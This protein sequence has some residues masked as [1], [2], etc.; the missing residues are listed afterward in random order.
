MKLSDYIGNKKISSDNIVIGID[1]GSRQAKAVLLNGDDFY[2][3]LTATGFDMNDTAELL[4][5]ELLG[6]SGLKREDIRYIVC[7]GYGRVAVSFP[8]IQSSIVTEIA[9]HGM[10][11]H[12]LAEDVKTIIDIGGQDSKAVKIDPQTGKVLDFA[13]NDKCAAG[14]GRFLERISAVLGEDVNTIGEI[15]VRSENP[16]TISAQCIVFAESE[17]VSGRAKGAKVEDL[18]A[19]INVSVVTRV[20]NLVSRIG[21][22]KNILFTGGVSNNI[23]IR[24]AFEKYLGIPFVDSKLDTVFAGAFGA[25]IFAIERSALNKS[26]INEESDKKHVNLY[27]LQ[28]AVENEKELIASGRTGKKKTVGYT[29]AYVPVEILSSADVAY[30]R[31]IHA[32]TQDEVMAGESVTQSVFCDMTKS[33]LGQFITENPLTK[34]TDQV[35]TFYTC[36]C[37]KNTV[38]AINNFYVPATM[39]NMPRLREEKFSLDYFRT[40]VL[41]FKEDVERLT[42]K[43]ITDEEINISI[44]LYNEAKKLIRQISE[45][46]KNDNPLISGS[47]FKQIAMSYYYLPVDILLRELVKIREQLNNIDIPK[48]KSNRPRILLS[49]GVAADGDDKVL[50]ILEEMGADIV[51]EDNCTGLRPFLNDVPNTGDWELDIAEAYLGKAPCARMKPLNHVVDNSINLAK[52]YRVDAVVFY[53]LKFCPCYSMIIRKYTDAFQNINIPI[54][55]IT[56]DYAHG[57][58]GQI[59]IRVEAFLEMLKS[60]KESL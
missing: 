9:C 16:A 42:G 30:Y 20:A 53:F 33:V 19:G 28:S 11:A 8:D 49:G 22:E 40:E 26:G 44:A 31:I 43:K 54:L 47:E 24:K 29:C 46:R 12:Y 6:S 37:M 41:H 32:G 39:Y 27:S 59:K 45:F 35:Y 15:S 3:A 18:A 23:G 60:N 4:I 17:I 50:K 5:S 1:I 58:E 34:A 51:A 21:I 55:V 7:T 57:D 38:E 14:T 36:D 2:T 48:T 25:A 13:M 52:E 10:G 56:S